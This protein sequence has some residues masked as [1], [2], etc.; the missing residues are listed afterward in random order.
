MGALDMTSQTSSSPPLAGVSTLQRVRSVV[1]GHGRLSVELAGLSDRDDLYDAGMTSRA[2]VGVMLAL[3][4]EF[5]VEFPDELLR[6]DVFQ[7][8]A[9]IASAVD[10]LVQGE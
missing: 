6:R 9:A 5:G 7:S 3:E 10:G 2:S 8:I 4:D 1:A